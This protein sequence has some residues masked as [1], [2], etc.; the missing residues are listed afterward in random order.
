MT[1][2][3]RYIGLMSGTSADGIDLAL[4]EFDPDNTQGANGAKLVASYYQAYDDSTQ[5]KIMSLYNPSDNEIDR[6]GSL[7]VELAQQFSRAILRFL[8]QENLTHA[9][10]AAIGSHGQTIRHRPVKNPEISAPLNENI[11]S[12][13]ELL[14]E[15]ESNNQIKI[16]P[17]FKYSPHI[18]LH[19][20]CGYLG[21]KR[22]FPVGD[23]Y[24]CGHPK[25]GN[26]LW[27]HFGFINDLVEQLM[28][29]RK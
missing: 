28:L 3:V 14:I 22:L 16:N 1:N 20:E 24:F 13:L 9:D 21:E 5:Q 18:N 4:V 25:V 6:A 27:T 11:Q 15:L 19:P 26:G 29:V 17:P 10:I 7:N 2:K 23:A 8:Q 12:L